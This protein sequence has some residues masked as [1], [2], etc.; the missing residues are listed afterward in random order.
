MQEEESLIHVIM[1]FVIAILLLSVPAMLTTQIEDG[2]SI[3]NDGLKHMKNLIN[4][5]SYMSYMSGVIFGF[6]GLVKFKQYMDTDEQVS[7]V[8]EVK[9][10]KSLIS[11]EKDS[12]MIIQEDIKMPDF[13]FN[14][15]FE[16]EVLNDK[17]SNVEKI[18]NSILSLP[19]LEKD[20][21]NKILVSSTQEKY[22]QQIHKAYIA[23]PL[24]L[25]NKEIRKSTATLLAMEQI[26]LVENGLI[27]IENELLNQQIQDLNIMNR[28]LKD[29]F[30][31]QKNYLT[32]TK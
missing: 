1:L 14:L 17:L 6:K 22:I 8:Q 4:L 10:E 31:E 3:F 15:D 13:L 24:E 20:I 19:V 27:E 2:G 16:N 30:P 12:S 5:M 28:F 7:S 23:I 11:L 32:L 25:R 18:I 21:Q 9:I 26:V 29:K